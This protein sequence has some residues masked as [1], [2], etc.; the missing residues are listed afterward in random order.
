ML[1]KVVTCIRGHERLPNMSV[2]GFW[3]LDNPEAH[4]LVQKHRSYW[5]CLGRQS[6]CE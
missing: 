5:I 1:D 6:H 2:W 3:M 4:L